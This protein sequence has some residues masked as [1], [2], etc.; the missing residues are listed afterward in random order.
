MKKTFEY[1]LASTVVLTAA[2]AAIKIFA[3]L[4]VSGRNR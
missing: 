1:V 3:V 2:S 4:M